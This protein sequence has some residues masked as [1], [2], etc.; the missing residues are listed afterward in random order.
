MAKEYNILALCE[1]RDSSEIN[2]P[3]DQEVARDGKRVAG[4]TLDQIRRSQRS[5]D[6]NAISGCV[7]NST[8]YAC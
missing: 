7:T 8:D 6:G 5:V 4:L 1:G 3:F 2:Q